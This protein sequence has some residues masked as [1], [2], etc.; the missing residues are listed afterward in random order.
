MKR[1][2]FSFVAL[3]LTLGTRADSVKEVRRL[4]R[5]AVE[6][7]APDGHILTLD[8]YGP[9]IVRLFRDDKGGIL[10]NPA[11]VPPADIL[12]EN[13]RK[14]ACVKITEKDGK[15]LIGAAN[16]LIVEIDKATGLLCL[17]GKDGRRVV[18]QTAPVT[19]AK[20]GYD[21]QLGITE[22]GILTAP[23][24][25]PQQEY[26]YGGGVQNGRFSHRGQRISIVNTNS[27]TDGGVCSPAPFYWSTAGYGVLCHTFR[28]GFYD[29]GNTVEGKVTLHHDSDYLDMFLWTGNSPVELL[30]GYY[31]LTGYPVLL[32]KF[33]FYEGH[34]NAYN[35]DYWKETDDT[36]RGILFEDGKYY[37]ESQ[38]PVEGGIRESLNG[39]VGAYQ[40]SGRAVIDRY[41]AADMPLGWVLPN[42]G[43]GAGYGQ[44]ETL[45]GNIQNLKAFGDYARKNGVEIGLWPQSH[46]PPSDSIPA[47]LQRDLVK[48]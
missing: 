8:F 23:G 47:L 3:L 6:V 11:A 9:N 35:R 10:R 1:T 24:S 43:Y 12:V 42:D 17:I 20:G 22:S 21:V 4:N 26:F 15:A 38:K 46:L 19:F 34:L 31:Q 48:E 28:P 27:W 18:E 2:I 30:D 32:P 37:T 41:N 44:T 45:D 16:G 25:A 5:Q 13:A 29:F 14:G 7:I 33:A 40:F 39:D 36:R